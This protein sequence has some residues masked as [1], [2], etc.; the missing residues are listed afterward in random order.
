MTLSRDQLQKLLDSH[1]PNS[2]IAVDA[3][4]KG[5]VRLRQVAGDGH[6]RPG[7]TVLG[8]VQMA[9]ADTAVYL[10]LIGT[11]R[12]FKAAVTSSLHISFLRRPPPGALSAHGRLVKI[13]S[14]LA[15]GEVY[16]HGPDDEDAPVAQ[17]TVT[18]ALPPAAD[19]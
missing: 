16:L 17:A 3:V 18:Y 6:L 11:G 15:V 2:G 7:G 14:R 12:P 5:S 9:L 4:G 1:F 13:G 10:A 8:P 19:D